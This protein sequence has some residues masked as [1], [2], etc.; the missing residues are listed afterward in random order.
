MGYHCRGGPAPGTGLLE[1]VLCRSPQVGARVAP[2]R[3]GYSA[4]RCS[5]SYLPLTQR[6][7]RL[8]ALTQLL[9]LSARCLTVF[10]NAYAVVLILVNVPQYLRYRYLSMVHSTK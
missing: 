10:R 1:A 6:Q 8:V 7:R 9:Q 3:A 5:L 2:A 4:I